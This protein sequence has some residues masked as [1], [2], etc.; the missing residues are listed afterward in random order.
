MHGELEHL[1]GYPVLNGSNIR[2]MM[3]EVLTQ[4]QRERFEERLELDTSHSIVGKGRFRVNLFVQRAAMGAVMRMIPDEVVPFESLGLPA[5]VR[6]FADL[7]RGLVLVTGPTGS[8]KS[9]TLASLVDV[10]NTSRS[11][12]I[13]TVEGPHRVRAPPQG[14]RGE[15][16]GGGG[17]T[18]TAS[19]P[20]S[21][22][23]CAR[24]PT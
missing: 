17:G 6:R 7:P 12:H 14:V 19:P 4:K 1:T 15:P 10:I 20:P 3:Y 24:T 5:S 9:T 11:D 16:A 23:C 21:S 8:G 22:T 13:M 2:R 18:P